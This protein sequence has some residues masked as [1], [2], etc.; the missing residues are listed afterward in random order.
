MPL[1]VLL[2]CGGRS[3][4]HEVS[5]AGARS[6]LAAADARLSITPLVIDRDGGFLDEARGRAAIEGGHA[7]GGSGS[8]EP[9]LLLAG[10]WDVV[11]PLLH[12]PNGEDGAPQGLLRLLGLPFVGPDVLGSAVAM[13][14]LVMKTLLA[15]EGVPQVAFR[16]VSRDRFETD[17]AAVLAR[18][19][20]WRYPLFV[21]PANLGSSV[22]ISRVETAAELGGA[23]AEAFRHDRRAVVEEGLEDVRELEIGLLGNGTPLAS[24]VGE[25]SFEGAFYD[26]ETKYSQGRA[27][28]LIPADVP[29]AVAAECRH[30]AQKAFR[31]LD[32]AGLARVDFFLSRDGRVLLNEVNTMPGFTETSMYP[33]LFR[34][35]GISYPDLLERLVRLALER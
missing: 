26:Y 20:S 32:L 18:F 7:E 29:A 3:A 28:L 33:R 9:A 8:P 5:L 17:P 21:K 4:E 30:L 1:K 31:A 10:G 25:V 14:K 24:P 19:G 12:G 23:L 22:G 11:F 27:R 2:L 34:E 16:R 35:A 13:D 15:A 6:I